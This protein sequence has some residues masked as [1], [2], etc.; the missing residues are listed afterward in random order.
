MV[1]QLAAGGLI[2]DPADIFFLTKEK[3]LGLERTADMSASNLLA[4]IGRTKKPPPDRLIFALGI[5]HVGEQTAK[6]LAD[7]HVTLDAL[8]AATFEALQTIRDIGPEVAASIA[9]FF[10]EPVN[11]HVLD[12]L[13]RAGV[14]PQ[15]SPAESHPL[16]G[17]SFVFTGTLGR[18][19][20]S[21]AKALWNPR[22]KSRQLRHETTN[23]V[24]AG[25]CRIPSWKRRD[26]A[27][28]PSSMRRDFSR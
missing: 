10:R 13:C 7:T 27:V 2:G 6:R 21:E 25:S 14:V 5:R 9:G 15:D 4:A 3:L 18:M 20:R 24:V 17:K 1:A 11:L 19:G 23:Y 12:K 22:R 8:A 16:A 26:E 28:S